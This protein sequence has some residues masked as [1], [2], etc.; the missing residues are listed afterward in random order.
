MA[1]LH[2]YPRRRVA[3]DY[4]DD[5]TP[6]WI[7]AK[8]EFAYAAN[9]VSLLMPYAEPIFI[10]CIRHYLPELDPDLRRRSMDYMRQEALHYT[11]HMQLNSMVAEKYPGVR[12]VERWM[13]KTMT[14]VWNKRSRRFSMAF[15]AGGETIA[16]AIARWTERHMGELFDGAEPVSTTLFLWHLA[17]EVEHKSAAWDVFDAV[18]GSRLRY[19]R[20][21]IIAMLVLGWFTWLGTFIMLWRDGRF[22][23]PVTWFRMFKWSIS[24]AF[25][26]FPTMV[27]SALPGHHPDDFT[28]PSY[29]STFLKQFDSKTGT[30]PI[31]QGPSITVKPSYGDA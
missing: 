5:W 1:K 17:E 26:L 30:M 22:F 8:P 9:S 28:D 18:D 16:Y 23:R 12:R 10:K 24:L 13:E 29:L 15:V 21:M 6:A 20:G 31:W 4:P 14:W 25:D 11:Q 3:F 2:E 19:A 27:A 7:P